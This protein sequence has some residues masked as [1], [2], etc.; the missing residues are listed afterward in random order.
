MLIDDGDVSN[1]NEDI[2]KLEKLE[3]M[4]LLCTKDDEDD[5]N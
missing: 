4:V 1:T 5:E 3:C 2:I